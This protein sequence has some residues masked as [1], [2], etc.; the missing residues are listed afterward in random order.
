MKLNTFKSLA[1]NWMS[2]VC[3]HFPD[4]L[5]VGVGLPDNL[6]DIRG[7]FYSY[8]EYEVNDMG[9]IY[10]DGDTGNV[11]CSALASRLRNAAATGEQKINELRGRERNIRACIADLRSQLER[12]KQTSSPCTSNDWQIIQQ[13][14]VSLEHTVAEMDTILA[15]PC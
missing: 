6:K 13:S 3:R 2:A 4:K 7:L 11:D 9:V 1:V 8:T 5:T 14:L 12:C 10:A 15:Q